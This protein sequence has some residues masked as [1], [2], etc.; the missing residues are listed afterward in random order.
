MEIL[1][2][3][4]VSGVAGDMLLSSLL[5]LGLPFSIWKREMKKLKLPITFRMRRVRRGHISAKF[6]EVKGEEKRVKSPK[7]FFSILEKANLKRAIRK[8][9]EEILFTLLAAEAGV[10]R[11]KRE[12]LHLHELGEYDT[13]FDIVGTLL[14]ID[15]LGIDKVYSS[16]IP[17]GRIK[18]PVTLEILKGTPVFEKPVDFEITTPTGACLVKSL[19]SDFIPLPLMR[20]EKIGYGTGTFNLES[21]NIL[22]A[23]IGVAVKSGRQV[24]MM[25]TNIDNLAP[26]IFGYLMDRLFNA[27]A[28]D[29]FFTPIYAK[30]NRP[31]I[32][33][34]LLAPEEKRE[35]LIDTL[36]FE[37]KTLGVRVYPIERYEAEREI[38][39][40]GTKYGKVKIKIGLWQGK[41]NL[42]FE[43]E[44]LKAIAQ[45]KKIPLKVLYQ[46]LSPILAEMGKGNFGNETLHP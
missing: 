3:D 24:F 28:L 29:V 7:E 42:S 30:K 22:R 16:P 23:L 19:A 36:F 43:Y 32:K 12:N 15:I 20:I 40:I 6:L 31:A 21:P 9:A 11:R 38:R 8:K 35:A 18:A 5:D 17:L 1:Y 33:V 37:T 25:E 27:G 39:E 41:K 2:L 34:S 45:R 13:L 4:L 14:A 26:E 10:H 46:E 44:N